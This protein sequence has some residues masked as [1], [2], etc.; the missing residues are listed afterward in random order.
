V[1]KGLAVFALTKGRPKQAILVSA[2][3]AATPD[4]L[5]AVSAGLAGALSGSS[6]LPKEWIAQVDKA[7]LADPYTNNKR[8]I[9]QTGRR[10][11]RGLR[12]QG[13]KKLKETLRAD[14]ASEIAARCARVPGPAC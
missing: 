14:G 11:A 12:R 1:A 4:C 9:E 5:A 8:T 13:P 7:T 10:P 2:T 3:S 6:S